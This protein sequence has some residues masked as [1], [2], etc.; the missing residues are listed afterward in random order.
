MVCPQCGAETTVGPG[1]PCPACSPSGVRPAPPPT[2]A[3]WL[4]APIGTAAEV[5]AAPA[6]AGDPPSTGR[7]DGAEPAPPAGGRRHPAGASHPTRR[8][9]LAGAAL[10]VVA[11][12]IGA[13]VTAGSSTHRAHRPA[14][15]FGGPV[16]TPDTAPPTTLAGTV[17]VGAAAGQGTEVDAAAQSLS[18]YFTDIDKADYTDAY[19]VFAPAEQQK[20]AEPG[21]AAGQATTQITGP[22]LERLDG[23]PAGGVDAEVWFTSHQASA[24]GPQGATCD[25]WKL[26]Y[27]LV[28]SAAGS[29]TP[30]QIDD[31]SST[32]RVDD[33]PTAPGGPTPC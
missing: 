28:P 19:A 16:G 5:P 27:H 26:T 12:A 1:Q 4:A 3:E 8:W 13:F 2:T 22:V 33:A 20:V 32:V 15:A 24:D 23:D 10:V 18:A 25:T 11:G 17:S 30:L 14:A 31:V 21:W 7:P 9:W 29:P 6:T